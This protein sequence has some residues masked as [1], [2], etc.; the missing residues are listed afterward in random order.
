MADVE[1]L[2][3]RSSELAFEAA[4]AHREGSSTATELYRKAADLSVEALR[5]VPSDRPKT[6]AIIGYSAANLLFKAGKFR[7]ASDLATVLLPEVSDERAR[8][9]LQVVLA[10]V[11]AEEAK[12]RSGA[13]FLPGQVVVSISGGA[14]L[15]GAAPLELVLRQVKN[16]QAAFVRVIEYLSDLPFQGRS[17]RNRLLDELCRPWIFQM[18]AGS[19]QFAIAVEEIRQPDFFKKH[20]SPFDIS[21]RFIDI[22]AASTSDNAEDLE[23]LIP[24]KQ[25]RKSF[26][27][28]AR[29]LSPRD[30]SFDQI[31]IYS[32]SATREIKMNRD[33][34]LIASQRLAALAPPSMSGQ[35]LEVR[36][37][38]RALDLD[39]DWLILDTT[40]GPVRINSLEDAVD[41]YIGSLVNRNVCVTC[42]STGRIRRFIDIFPD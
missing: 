4:R 30:G 29:R 34:S 24:D 20:I 38:L 9:Q 7:E 19:Y 27:Q 23:R 12:E 16:V 8:E 5:L 39:K 11:W 33:A 36:G 13:K 18:P 25:Y 35:T 2:S 42:Y 3:N 10:S 41:D 1:W 14:V 17:A 37:R 28:L 26:V 6:R 31:R 15:T 32:P 22:L 40:D 21:E